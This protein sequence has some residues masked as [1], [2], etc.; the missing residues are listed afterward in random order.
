MSPS[1]KDSFAIQKDVNYLIGN[2]PLY[3]KYWTSDAMNYDGEKSEVTLF[4]DCKDS[5]RKKKDNWMQIR[6]VMIECLL[7]TPLLFVTQKYDRKYA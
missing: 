2:I 6:L 5:R 7:H 1:D 3:L 4:M